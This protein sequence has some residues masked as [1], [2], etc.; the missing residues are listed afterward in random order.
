MPVEIALSFFHFGPNMWPWQGMVNHRSLEPGE[1]KSNL[2]GQ[3]Q[4]SDKVMS[5]LTRLEGAISVKVC[6]LPATLAAPGPDGAG[7]GAG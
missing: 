1:F 5:P 2:P 4:K 3:R 6:H 7:A